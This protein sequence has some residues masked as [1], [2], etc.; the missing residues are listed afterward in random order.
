MQLF[1]WF[2]NVKIRYQFIAIETQ[3]FIY[4]IKHIS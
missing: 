1:F 2:F 4:D 3:N